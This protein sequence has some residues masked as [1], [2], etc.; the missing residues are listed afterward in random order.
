M[1]T[2]LTGHGRGHELV[3]RARAVPCRRQPRVEFACLPLHLPQV[4]VR[5]GHDGATKS[6]TVPLL[7]VLSK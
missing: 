7:Q 1:K 4:A 3:T 5:R 6:I 2:F